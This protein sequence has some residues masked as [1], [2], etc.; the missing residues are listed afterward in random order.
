[1]LQKLRFSTLLVLP[2]LAYA[3]LFAP[4]AAAEETDYPLVPAAEAVGEVNAPLLFVQNLDATIASD[5]AAIYRQPLGLRLNDNLASAVAPSI[6]Q[7][8]LRHHI[9]DTA[10]MRPSASFS[11]SG[12][13]LPPKTTTPAQYALGDSRQFFSYYYSESHQSLLDCTGYFSAEVIA[14]GNHCTIWL[15]DGCNFSA[16][17]A[18]R[19]AEKLDEGIATLRSIFGGWSSFDVDGDGKAAF[20]LYP[21]SDAEVGGY[22]STG[23]LYP[24]LD[25]GLGHTGNGMD[26]LNINAEVAANAAESESWEQLLKI[27]FHEWMHL[28]CFE[29]TGGNEDAWLSEVVAQ[30]GAS[31]AGCTED[32]FAPEL[33]TLQDWYATYCFTPPF[34][35]KNN[36]LPSH[37]ALDGASYGSWYLFGQYLLAQT[38]ASGNNVFKLL[39]ESGAC[40]AESLMT[41]LGRLSLASDKALPHDLPSLVSN[42]NLALLLQQP[43]GRYSLGTAGTALG[44]LAPKSVAAGQDSLL[45]LLQHGLPGGGCCSWFETADTVSAIATPSTDEASW[46]KNIQFGLWHSALDGQSAAVQGAKP[47][48]APS[49][50]PAPTQHPTANRF[51]LSGMNAVWLGVA[52]V[53]A[54]VG[55]LVP[56][57]LFVQTKWG[58]RNQ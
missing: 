47:A 34:V 4:K 25:A 27:M 45:Q 56:L 14:V 13:G 21:F 44:T 29:H 32:A 19:L 31:L 22:C 11:S 15:A 53:V 28:I 23:D 50:S 3:V 43:S 26:M 58:K 54:V 8:V 5:L 16:S 36:F 51:A 49:P 2:V 24:T 20:V 37:P 1:M 57:Y 30:T 48:P 40:T 10:R 41:V 46:Q 9:C 39:L 42:F 33:E 55:A 35:Y 12:G 38:N 7:S 6:S 18:Q 52:A 17:D